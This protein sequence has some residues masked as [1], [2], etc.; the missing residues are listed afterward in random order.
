MKKPGNVLAIV[1]GAVPASR[2]MNS[3]RQLRIRHLNDTP[4]E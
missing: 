2:W 4:A 3:S 1:V